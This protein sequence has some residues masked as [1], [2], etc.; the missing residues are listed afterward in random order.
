MV[1][2]ASWVSSELDKRG[3]LTGMNDSL[4]LLSKELGISHAKIRSLNRKLFMTADQEGIEEMVAQFN[5]SVSR[6]KQVGS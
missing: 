3:V 5:R 1:R 4:L 2:K 6:P